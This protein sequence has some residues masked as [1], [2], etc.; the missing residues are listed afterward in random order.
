MA[1]VATLGNLAND[2]V[3]RVLRAIYRDQGI[4]SQEVNLYLHKK[5]FPAH[6]K[7]AIADTVRAV[8][9]NQESLYVFADLAP[10]ANWGHPARHMFFSPQNATLLHSELSD[11]P[12][13]EFPNN[14][15]AFAELHLPKVPMIPAE[16]PFFLPRKSAVASR[17]VKRSGRCY[18]ILFSGNSNNRHV[19]DMEFLFRV[20]CDV[21]AYK[22]DD[23]YVLNYDGTLNYDGS[24]K[25][26]ANWPGDGTAYRIKGRIV[27]AGNKADFDKI[28]GIL[29]KKLK[30]A[31]TLVIHTN[32]HGGHA[33]TYGE[34]YL[35]GYPSFGLVYKASDF[36]QRLAKMPKYR[37][38]IV[39]MEQCFSG[40]FM[41]PTLTNSTATASS[42]AAAV[43]ANMPSQIGT[44]FDPW[45]LDWIAA[46]NGVYADGSALKYPV[47]AKPSTRQAF[48][49][50][51][52]VHVPGDFP[53]FDDAP[54]GV[55][56]TQRLN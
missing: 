2:I 21:Y 17:R 15:D 18:A 33:S 34:T 29:S 16:A 49:Y 56:R 41:N 7:L 20:L 28:F 45:A 4:R 36:G 51:S 24:P 35:C 50:T 14:P 52:T 25:P 26:V 43:P 13:R 5:P 27:G 1:D 48:N 11:F 46:F 39:G 10:L 55:G 42:F 22:P 38:L 3:A 31:D 54:S 12:P 47:A 23:I 6:G 37:S 53:V 9:T 19:N 32:N 30:A 44:N 8:P 40:G